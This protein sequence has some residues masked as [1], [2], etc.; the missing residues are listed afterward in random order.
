M[1]ASSLVVA[2]IRTSSA[3]DLA[4][5]TSAAPSAVA[6]SAATWAT[7]ATAWAAASSFVV[8]AVAITS[9]LVTT[10]WVVIGQRPISSYPC[11]R[12]EHLPGAVRC[13]DCWERAG[14]SAIVKASLL[15]IRR[16]SWMDHWGR[17][18]RIAAKSRWN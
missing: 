2:V 17:A 6:S 18:G 11:R 9:S 1:V 13:Q 4:S 5:A 10:S 12:S 3:T 8:A 14:A 7:W 16:R 15:A